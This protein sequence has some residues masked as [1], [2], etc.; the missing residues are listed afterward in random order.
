MPAVLVKNAY[1][2][3]KEDVDFLKTKKGKE[4]LKNIIIGGIKD[5]FGV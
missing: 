3:N 4:T 1:L 5:Y 2:D